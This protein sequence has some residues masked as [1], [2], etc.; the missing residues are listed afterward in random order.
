MV[1][2]NN[3]EGFVGNHTH[4]PLFILGT[5]HSMSAFGFATKSKFTLDED[6]PIQGVHMPKILH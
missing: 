2:K 6:N 3:V 1:F 5:I 4:F